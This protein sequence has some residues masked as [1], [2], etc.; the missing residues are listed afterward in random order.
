MHSAIRPF[1]AF[2]DQSAWPA[3]DTLCPSLLPTRTHAWMAARAGIVQPETVLLFTVEDKNTIAALAPLIQHAG[4]LLELP[5]MFEPGDLVWSSPESL[6][7]LAGMLARQPLPLHLERVAED[8]PTIAALRRAFRW[9]GIVLTR[10]AMPTPF[11]D[12]T[13]QGGDPDACLTAR[14]RSDLRR[15]ERRARQLGE[16]RYELHAPRSESEL[17]A[18][19]HEAMAV[20]ARS[21]K[22]E[23]GTALT[24][25]RTQGHFFD[26]FASG[27]M[28]EG[29][30]RI[31]LLRID[32]RAVAM[33]IAGEW[34]QRFWLFKIS[35]DRAYDGCSPGQLLLWHTLREAARGGL[36]AY[37]FMGIMAPWTELWTQ[38]QRRYRNVYAIPFSPG[39]FKMLAKRLLRPV[40]AR[41][42]RFKR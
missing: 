6:H 12:L 18:L 25:D 16:V 31:A 36:L 17:S 23:A 29:M 4:W 30:L 15:A 7:A 24:A 5:R 11:I 10:E 1:S 39:V 26:Q 21:W 8:S 35:H 13:A 33:Q 9:R 32:G 37:E 41:L 2:P 27:A 38:Q 3:F 42:R 20:E 14:R 22:E 34:K 28:R 40:V 19:M